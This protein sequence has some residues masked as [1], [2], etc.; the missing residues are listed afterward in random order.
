MKFAVLFIIGLFLV[1]CPESVQDIMNKRER[2][3]ARDLQMTAET[4]ATERFGHYTIQGVIC[5]PEKSRR[6][7]ARRALCLVSTITFLDLIPLWCTNDSCE[8]TWNLRPAT[9]GEIK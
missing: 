9:N 2:E 5:F 3:W 4:V 1:G 7:P 8:S 6:S